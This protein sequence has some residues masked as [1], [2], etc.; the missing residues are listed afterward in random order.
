MEAFLT[1]QFRTRGLEILRRD[2][3]TPFQHQNGTTAIGKFR[4]K[5][6]TAGTG[7]DQDDVVVAILNDHGLKGGTAQEKELRDQCRPGNGALHPCQT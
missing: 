4:R 7:A 1:K 5:G 6:G 2:R 3:L